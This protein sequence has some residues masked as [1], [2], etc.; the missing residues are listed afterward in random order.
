[1]DSQELVKLGLTD[2]EAKVYLA[3]LKTGSATVGPLVK[4]SKVAYSNIYEI[5]DRLV[6]KGLASFII[7]SKTHY[8]QAV[9]PNRL[10][11]YLQKQRDNLEKQEQLLADLVPKLESFA[12]LAETAVEAE[13]FVG[14]KAMHSAQEKLT[15]HAKKGDEELFFYTHSKEYAEKVDKLFVELQHFYRSKGLVMRGVA[16][17][18]YRNYLSYAEQSDYLTM[19]F[20]EFPIP[21]GIDICNDCVLLTAWHTPLAVLITSRELADNFRQVFEDVW[22]RAKE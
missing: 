3:L 11:D 15:E 13:A 6:E 19:R 16:N 1:M 2:G 12:K 7:K 22:K 17:T 18:D 5:L 20:V 4:E 8:Y 9:Q 14:W 21:S 10:K